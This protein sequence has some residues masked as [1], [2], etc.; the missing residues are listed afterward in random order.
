MIRRAW[1]ATTAEGQ[2]RDQFAN[3][4]AARVRNE[5]EP[6]PGVSVELADDWLETADRLYR[7]AGEPTGADV[8]SAAENADISELWE[9]R[10]EEE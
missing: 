1:N 3:A 6:H 9:Y 7:Q 5:I 10:T 4:L 8:S 2:S